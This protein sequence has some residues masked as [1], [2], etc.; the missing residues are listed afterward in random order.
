M[1]IDTPSVASHL[2]TN[3]DAYLSS[4]GGFLRRYS[5]DELPQLFS[6][7][8]GDMSFVGPRPALNTQDDLIFLRTQKGVD[9]LVPGITGW[10]QVNG[11]DELSLEDKAAF[12]ADYI[13]LQSFWFDLKILWIT[14]FK[15]IKKD[16]VSH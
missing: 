10:A 1:L 15:V 9:K 11:R 14:F 5:L 3:P 4:I 6:I 2:L 7:L 13:D 8:K 16:N 12:D